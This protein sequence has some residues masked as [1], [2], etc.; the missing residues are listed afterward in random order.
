MPK[1][2]SHAAA[3][4][5]HAPDR[6]L[7]RTLAYLADPEKPA[8]P[9]VQRTADCAALTE[10]AKAH[11]VDA[12]LWRKLGGGYD[13]PGGQDMLY[14]IAQAM[15]LERLRHEITAALASGGTRASVVKGPVFADRLYAMHGD[16]L[17]TDIDLL[18][19]ESAMGAAIGTMRELG[20]VRADGRQDGQRRSME[21]KFTHPAH[22]HV[23]IELHG[24]MV[25][26]PLLR[27]RASFG[28]RELL[29]AGDGDGETGGA[30]LATAIV[31][32]TLGHK[33]ER[34]AMLV[35][36][37]QAARRLPPAD[38]RRF[39][40]TLSAMRL[41]LECAVCLGVTAALFEDATCADLASL[42]RKNLKD[43][44]GAWLIT[45][46]A[47]IAAGEK[48]TNTSWLR[49]KSFRLMQYLP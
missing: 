27:R 49:R 35:D 17:F 6:N 30:L 24:D 20:Y 16:R 42:F 11:G 5:R 21:Y 8:P 14:R 29:R 1:M 46:Q 25:H 33:F 10:L 3:R 15:L 36:V 37:L 31:H 12:I 19:E 4:A 47:V 23:L 39:A 43:R 40:D 38:H 34:L 7:Y 45:P 2:A 22:A 26:Y 44:I 9:A 13:G 48:S 32:A 28:R 41:D 18:V